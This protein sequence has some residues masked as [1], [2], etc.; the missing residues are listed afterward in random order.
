M[1][2]QINMLPDTEAYSC[3]WDQYHHYVCIKRKNNPVLVL[4]LQTWHTAIFN[5]WLP[6]WKGGH[7]DEIITTL[8]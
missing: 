5:S 8:F 7:H 6:Q 4:N 2:E 1:S 3:K